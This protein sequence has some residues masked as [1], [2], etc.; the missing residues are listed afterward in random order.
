MIR[1]IL[2]ML[3]I[4]SCGKS[5]C[6]STQHYK[7][8]GQN[9]GLIDAITSNNIIQFNKLIEAGANVN[10]RDEFG[11]APL[12]HALMIDNVP[13]SMKLVKAGAN[14]HMK[15]GEGMTPL[16]YAVE[17]RNT[18]LVETFIKAGS[19]VNDK[20]YEN[21][22][23]LCLAFNNKDINCIIL[24]IEAGAKLKDIH[25]NNYISLNI[26]QILTLRKQAIEEY[27]IKEGE[28]NFTKFLTGKYKEI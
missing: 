24:L 21:S 12:H 22:T 5:K 19:N 23:P 18:Y 20:N 6:L 25:K 2:P 1:Y 7:V 16:M 14:I 11:F 15:D 26:V 3:I 4:M 10:E 28:N 13:I 27:K 8:K 9:N 17:Y